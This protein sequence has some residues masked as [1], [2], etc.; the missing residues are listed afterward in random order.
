MNRTGYTKKLSLWACAVVC[1]T[2]AAPPAAGSLLDIGSLMERETFVI[3]DLVPATT[4]PFRVQDPTWA[5]GTG[6]DPGRAFGIAVVTLHERFENVFTAGILEINVFNHAEITPWTPFQGIGFGAN[7][8]NPE[9]WIPEGAA[10]IPPGRFH[11]LYDGFIL[12]LSHQTIVVRYNRFWFPRLFGFFRP[13]PEP[14]EP[15]FPMEPMEPR[16]PFDPLP[17]VEPMEPVEPFDP[18]PPIPEPGTMT[19]VGIGLAALAGRAIRRRV[20]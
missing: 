11:L 1:A 16:E 19:L 15:I 5:L 12:G 4:G 13:P 9:G 18:M 14:M 8:P 17:P 7:G 3:T 2:V 20:G 10:L 6:T